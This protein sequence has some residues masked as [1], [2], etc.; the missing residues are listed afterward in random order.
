MLSSSAKVDALIHAAKRGCEPAVPLVQ[1]ETI[2][3]TKP[4]GI[5]VIE[6]PAG[7]GGT[8]TIPIEITERLSVGSC[9]DEFSTRFT[10]KA[11]E[12]HDIIYQHLLTCPS[13]SSW[14]HTSTPPRP[15]PQRF[16]QTPVA[17]RR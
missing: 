8:L 17:K 2:T 10:A 12:L 14:I 6:C 13:T 4:P 5:L 7:C 1:P 9:G 3:P 16:G 15:A 11:P